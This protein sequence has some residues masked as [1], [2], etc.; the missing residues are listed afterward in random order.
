M[1]KTDPDSVS[2]I[3]KCYFG[4]YNNPNLKLKKET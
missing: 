3:Y 2:R 4:L 1:H